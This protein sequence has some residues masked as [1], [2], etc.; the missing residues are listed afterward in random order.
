MDQFEFLGKSL[1]W[2]G[3]VVVLIG[4]AITYGPRLIGSWRL[5]GDIVI[6]KG[7][8]TFFFPLATSLLLSLVLTLGFFLLNLL[9]RK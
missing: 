7:N 3:V 9:S 8:F 6:K 4:L 5:P 2:L 1:I